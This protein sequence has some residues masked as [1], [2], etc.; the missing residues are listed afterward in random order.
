M[1]LD[2]IFSDLSHNHMIAV[3][4]DAWHLGIG[5]DLSLSVS[6]RNVRSNMGKTKKYLLKAKNVKKETSHSKP[7]G[8]NLYSTQNFITIYFHVILS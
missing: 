2:R 4:I 5:H 6:L 3:T 1:L 7:R 8:T